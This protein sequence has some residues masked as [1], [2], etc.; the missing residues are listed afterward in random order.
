MSFAIR[1]YTDA[2]HAAV[3]DLFIRINAELA[4]PDVRNAFAEYTAVSLRDEIDRPADYYAERQGSFW[5][6]YDGARLARMFGLE[7]AGTAPPNCAACMWMRRT[8]NAGLPA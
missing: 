1:R 6:A 3:R 5:V 4:P 8:A 7:R 2:D